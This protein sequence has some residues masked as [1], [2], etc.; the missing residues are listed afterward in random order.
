ME[1]AGMKMRED[2]VRLE[3]TG[4]PY[5]FHSHITIGEFIFRLSLSFKLTLCSE[6]KHP[7]LTFVFLHNS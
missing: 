4:N 5:I 2:G 1:N 7:L 3:K 6:K